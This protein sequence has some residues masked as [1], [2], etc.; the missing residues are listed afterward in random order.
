MWSR[1]V[2]RAVPAPVTVR[3]P[4]SRSQPGLRRRRGG[5][6]LGAAGT[7]LAACLAAGLAAGLGSTPADADFARGGELTGLG[8][9]RLWQL[10]IDPGAPNTVLAAT[11]AGVLLSLDRGA[12]WRP[13]SLRGARAWTVGFDSRADSHGAHSAY[14]GLDGGGLARS[15]DGKAWSDASTGLPSRNVRVLAIGL[16]GLAV[17]TDNGVAV[18]ADGRTWRPAGLGGYGVSALAVSA[19]APQFTLV[20]GTDSAPPAGGAGFLFR[21][22][23]LG[24]TWEPL[25]SGLPATAV[26][27]AVAAGPLPQSTMARPLLAATDKGAFHS[28]DGGTTWTASAGPSGETGGV[29]ALTLTT[30]QFSPVDPNLVYAGNDAGGNSGGDLFRSTDAGATFAPADR[31]LADKQ[32]NV[33]TVAVAG[34]TPPLILAGVDPPGG[35]ALLYS[36]TDATAP[37]PGAI[38]PESGAALPSAVPLP[39]QGPPPRSTPAPPPPPPSGHGGLRGLYDRATGWPFPLS[40]ELLVILAVVYAGFRWYQRRLDIEGPP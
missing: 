2:G 29:T 37:A 22:V 30:A 33:A 7:G 15:D 28:G 24:P 9:G 10:A 8:A 25:S 12:T 13:T 32:R 21:N 14:A 4:H 26:V 38:A 3:R 19:N 35:G 34:T 27:S 17:G 18:S 16:S 39:T 1:A 6:G 40:V 5:I 11:D 31:G 36:E 23:G 20:A